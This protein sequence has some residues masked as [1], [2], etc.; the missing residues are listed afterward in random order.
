[1]LSEPFLVDANFIRSVILLVEH[2]NK[3]SIGFVINRP[4]NFN[5]R[6]AIEDFPVINPILYNGGPCETNTLHY[7]HTAGKILEGSTEIIDGVYWGGNHEHMQE[8][9][10]EGK[11]HENQFKFFI[12]Y[13]GWG[14]QQ[15]DAELNQKSWIV[16]PA[17]EAYLF[18][19]PAEA[20][21]KTV[22]KSM[23]EKYAI[24]AEAPMDPNW[25]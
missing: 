25:N 12:G 21:W 9:F 24:L 7:I 18:K 13:S 3:G 4:M 10:R 17:S 11:V 5:M 16:T 6:D 20:L 23:G 8:L 2:G 22:L 14:L 15:L 19:T 1:L